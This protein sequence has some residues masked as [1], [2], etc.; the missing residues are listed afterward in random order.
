[1]TFQT[2]VYIWT[3]LGAYGLVLQHF[4]VRFSWSERSLDDAAWGKKKMG[5]VYHLYIFEFGV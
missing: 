1:M 4:C 5:F 2:F 3:I